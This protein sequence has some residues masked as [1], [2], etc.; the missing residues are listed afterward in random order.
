[1]HFGFALELSD[2]DLWNTDL[3]GT[4]LDLLGTDISSKYF[5][6]LYNVFKTSSSHVFKTPWRRRQRKNFSSAMQDIFKTSSRHLG[7]RKIV[8]YRLVRYLLDTDIPSKYFVGLHN[9]FKTSSRHIFRRL[10]VV[11]KCLHGVLQDVFKTSPRRVQDLLVDVKLLRWRPLKTSSRPTDVCWVSSCMFLFLF[12]VIAYP[13]LKY[14][15]INLYPFSYSLVS[16]F[17]LL[18]FFRGVF[19]YRALFKGF[20]FS[21]LS[22]L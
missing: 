2:I 10:E 11:L 20:R 16:N 13:L 9:V 8:R 7:R 1:M 5:V 4:N 14:W 15:S 3:L 6:C 18:Y 22:S 21:A 17:S 12:F 19:R